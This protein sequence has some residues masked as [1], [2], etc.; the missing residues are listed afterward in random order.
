MTFS[1]GEEYYLQI[2]LLLGIFISLMLLRAIYKLTK[3]FQSGSWIK[4]KAKVISVRI[5]SSRDEDGDFWFK[6]KIK[7]Q[8]FIKG[9]MHISTWYSYK[10]METT[11]Y[12]SVSNRLAGINKNS[13][14]SIYV[15]PKKPKQSVVVQGI[16][17][18]NIFEIGV[19]LTMLVFMSN[20]IKKHLEIE[21]YNNHFQPTQKDARVK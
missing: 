20:G 4:S 17:W 9:K 15:N 2:I 11:N 6:P 14:I 18:G 12:G 7:Y 19:L 16:S 10:S 21:S 8:Y 5:N 3:G 1:P 13:E